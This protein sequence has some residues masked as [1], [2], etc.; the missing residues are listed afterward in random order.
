[1]IL[2][3]VPPIKQREIIRTVQTLTGLDWKAV[4]ALMRQ[5]PQPI[6]QRASQQTAEDLK[7]P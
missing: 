6:Q 7:P 5:L 2:E 4:K 1:V 3:A